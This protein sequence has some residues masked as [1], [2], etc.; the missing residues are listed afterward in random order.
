MT[1]YGV[2]GS[3]SVPDEIEEEAGYNLGLEIVRTSSSLLLSWVSMFDY[4]NSNLLD[5][6]HSTNASSDAQTPSGF[7]IEW[8][9]RLDDCEVLSCLGELYSYFNVFDTALEIHKHRLN[10]V[11]SS[12]NTVSK[13]K[14]RIVEV[15]IATRLAVAEAYIR[16]N[17]ENIDK[18]TE[19]YLKCESLMTN[20]VKIPVELKARVLLGLSSVADNFEKSRVYLDR[21]TRLPLDKSLI[22]MSI[23]ALKKLALDHVNMDRFERAGLYV[24]EAI[25][26]LEKAGY[27]QSYLQFMGD[28]L[29]LDR[30]IKL[31]L[32]NK[33]ASDDVC[34]QEG[35]FLNMRESFVEALISGDITYEPESA[36]LA[37]FIFMIGSMLEKGGRADLAEQWYTKADRL[38]EHH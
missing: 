18:A 5:R 3:S 10:L 20:D 32:G 30:K 19:Q 8:T 12:A 31:S 23:M 33:K 6:S 34:V 1:I 26:K 25:E 27:I 11:R 28:L 29:Y 15:E 4:P 16:S 14:S 36:R 38:R 9:R 2:F 17:W 7:V 22:D 21:L 13:R 24:R 35:A 37:L